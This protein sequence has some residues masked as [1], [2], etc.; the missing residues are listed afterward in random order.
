VDIAKGER[1]REEPWQ[2]SVREYNARCGDEQR[3]ERWTTT[4]DRPAA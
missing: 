1:A 2:K 3:P 4:R